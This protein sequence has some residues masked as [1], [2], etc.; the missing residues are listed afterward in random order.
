MLGLEMLDL[1][2]IERSYQIAMAIK[3]QNT[4]Q[5]PQQPAMAG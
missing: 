2:M 1:E 4:I 3:G 5:Q